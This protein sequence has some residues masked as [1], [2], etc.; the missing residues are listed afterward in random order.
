MS[1]LKNTL[2]N[3]ASQFASSVLD[4]LRGASLDELMRVSGGGGGGARRGARPAAATR[5]GRGGRLGRR[6]QDEIEKV[7]E[8]IVGLLEKNPD[9]MRAEQ[10][11]SSLGVEAK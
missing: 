3:L 11:R 10:I 9:G 7:D 8:S 4:A 6:T 5:R 1:N 2:E